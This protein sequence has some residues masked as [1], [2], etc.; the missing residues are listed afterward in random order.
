MFQKKSSKRVIPNYQTCMNESC[1]GK[2]FDSDINNAVYVNISKRPYQLSVYCST[3]CC[4]ED[5]K[6]G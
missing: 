2:I 5:N 4:Y 3:E 6:R 1:S